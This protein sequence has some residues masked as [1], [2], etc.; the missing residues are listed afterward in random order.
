MM[1][2][3]GAVQLLSSPLTCPR[4]MRKHPV[5][6]KVESIL[7]RSIFVLLDNFLK[8]GLFFLV[9]WPFSVC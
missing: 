5:F 3:R 6:L 7:E 4:V 2:K 1:K 8:M 9:T